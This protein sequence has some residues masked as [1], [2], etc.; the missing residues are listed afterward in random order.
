MSV[1]S[2][3]NDNNGCFACGK[4]NPI[5]LHLEF[6]QEGEE[7]VTYFTPAKE[8]QGWHDITHGGIICTVLDEVMARYVYIK[9]Y[10]AVT[11]EMT[12]RMKR[13]APTGSRLR[14]A[15]KIDSESHRVINCSACATD[16]EGNL[17]AEAIGKM[18][19][20]R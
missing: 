14:V 17:I 6:E 1:I 18:V 19:R 16:D 3:L 8:H 20:I 2:K 12:V 13:P 5:G 4:A 11:G 15:G 10:N 7:Y 9:G